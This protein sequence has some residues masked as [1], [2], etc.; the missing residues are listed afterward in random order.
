MCLAPFTAF[1]AGVGDREEDVLLRREDGDQFGCI[2]PRSGV[3]LATPF[4]YLLKAMP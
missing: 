3:T 4:P 1:T 2:L